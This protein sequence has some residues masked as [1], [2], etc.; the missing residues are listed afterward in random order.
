MDRRDGGHLREKPHVRQVRSV[1][2]AVT[3]WFILNE[4]GLSMAK[5]EG[6]KRS[7]Q[8]A[9][10]V[11]SRKAR[12]NSSKPKNRVLKQISRAQSKVDVIKKGSGF[13]GPEKQASKV[14]RRQKQRRAGRADSSPNTLGEQRSKGE[15]RKKFTDVAKDAD[16]GPRNKRGETAREAKSRRNVRPMSQRSKKEKGKGFKTTGP[17]AERRKIRRRERKEANKG[18]RREERR[19]GSISAKQSKPKRKGRLLS[20]AQAKAKKDLRAPS[21]ERRSREDR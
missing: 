14:E 4:K 7:D 3:K 19:K 11:L 16:R 18:R 9:K 10:K 2:T 13:R 20:K 5:H 21:K 8:P 12:A 6:L 1:D 15:R 17:R